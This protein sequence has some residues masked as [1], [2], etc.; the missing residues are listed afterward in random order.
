MG[1]LGAVSVI[2]RCRH[3]RYVPGGAGH[4]QIV[5]TGTKQT[6]HYKNTARAVW[7]HSLSCLR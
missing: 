6:G 2:T 5:S 1:S 4:Q 7:M 3:V